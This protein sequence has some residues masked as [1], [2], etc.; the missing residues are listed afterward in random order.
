MPL[1]FEKWTV[2]DTCGVCVWFVEGCKQIQNIHQRQAFSMSIHITI[3][4][5]HQIDLPLVALLLPLVATLN[6]PV[7]GSRALAAGDTALAAR[8]WRHAFLN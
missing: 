4:P 3:V 6:E 7:A 5:L 8:R 1:Q 2:F